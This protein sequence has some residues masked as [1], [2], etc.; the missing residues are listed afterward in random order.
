[1]VDNQQTLRQRKHLAVRIVLSVLILF[2]LFLACYQPSSLDGIYYDPAIACDHGFWMFKDG[3][4][5][6]GCEAEETNFCGTYFKSANQWLSGNNP[7]NQ[8]IIKPSLFGI[9]MTGQSWKGGRKF[10]LR[11]CFSW[12][13]D[14][15]EWIENHL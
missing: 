3:K 6:A 9:E 13:Y 1:M 15:K 4:I 2:I 5:F 7:T 10:I 8:M 11:D 14:C 12:C